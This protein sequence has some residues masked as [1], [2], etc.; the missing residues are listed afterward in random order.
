LERWGLHIWDEYALPPWNEISCF[1]HLG[2]DSFIM[3]SEPAAPARSDIEMGILLSLSKSTTL[4]WLDAS[5]WALLAFG[6][7][8]VV[9]LIVEYYAEHGSRWMK[10]G[11][12]LVIIGVA[13]ELLGDGGIF[14]FSRHL[15]TISEQEIAEVTKQAGEA[16]QKAGESNERAGKA[17]ER[18]SSSEKEAARLRKEAESEH[19]ARVKIEQRLADRTLTRQQ[20]V[21]I[22][23]KLKPFSGQEFETISYPENHEASSISRSI[24]GAIVLAHWRYSNPSGAMMMG[25]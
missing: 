4:F 19:L 15:Q 23:D 24:I 3:D 1:V 7:L 13:G 14:L 9:G 10:V 16:N 18:A 6:A 17:N 20:V 11:E 21:A 22:A 25:I 12:L 5:E 8:L 2:W